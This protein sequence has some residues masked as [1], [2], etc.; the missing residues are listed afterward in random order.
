MPA[1]QGFFRFVKGRFTVP[2]GEAITI[3]EAAAAGGARPIRERYGTDPNAPA[4]T[5]PDLRSAMSCRGAP[6]I[7]PGYT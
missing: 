6:G 3:G 5:I 7:R 2:F 4:A 1:P